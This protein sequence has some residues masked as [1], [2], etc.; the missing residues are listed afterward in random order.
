MI[1]IVRGRPPQGFQRRSAAG[2]EELLRQHQRHT[3]AA[4][5]EP[6]KP[7]FDAKVWNAAKDKLRRVQHCKCAYTEATLEDVKHV[8]HFR[9]KGS[10]RN[11]K[12][13]QR[14]HPGYFWL[15]Y[16]WENLLLTNAQVN[17]DK[18]D[19]FPLAKPSR[20]AV[21][22]SGSLDDEEPVLIDPA[23]EDPREHI[24]FH[25]DA[26]YGITDRGRGTVDMLGLD[27]AYLREKRME[28]LKHLQAL[29]LLAN[30][31]PLM[32]LAAAVRLDPEAELAKSVQPE[33]KFSS[34]AID[35]LESQ[36]R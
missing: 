12:G 6:F 17:I 5:S 33:A 1:R 15:A 24:R 8:E 19:C 35:F 29:L 14:H 21:S 22:P 7:V 9:P 32:A 10:V 27:Q 26:P 18:S 31:P 23:Q 20:R 30:H 2:R 3:S 25:N 34:M 13:S 28:R 16:E 36:G 4:A 11:Q